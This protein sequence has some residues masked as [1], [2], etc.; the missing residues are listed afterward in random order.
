[1]ELLTSDELADYRSVFRDAIVGGGDPAAAEERLRRLGLLPEQARQIRLDYEKDAGIIRAVPDPFAV[2][3]DPNR[4]TWFAGPQLADKFWPRVRTSLD[5]MLPS[6]AVESIDESSNYVLSIMDP[7]GLSSIDTRG[8]VV[9]YVQSGKTTNF[10]SLISK[11]AD[12]GYRVFIVLSGITENLRSQTQQRVDELLVGSHAGDWTKLTTL[13]SDFTEGTTNAAAMLGQPG[14]RFIAVVKKNPA[15]LRRLHKWL[16][17]AGLVALQNAPILLIDDE[18]DQASINV[19][20]LNKRASTINDLLKHILNKP[21]AAY[22][23]YTATP[24]ANLLIDTQDDEDLYPRDFVV[25]LPEPDEYFGP[26][27]LFGLD[28]GDAEIAQD[29]LDVIRSIPIDEAARSRP[30][31]GRDAVDKWA[32]AVEPALRDA[33]R[34]FIMST[35]ARM[36]RGEGNAHATMLVHTSMLARAHELLADEIRIEIESCSAG[37]NAGSDEFVA[38]WREQYLSEVSAVEAANFGRT[39]VAFGD[40][41][42]RVPEVLQTIHVICDN[43]RSTERLSYSA[44][45]AQVTIVVGGNTLSRGLTLEGLSS[46]YFVRAASAYDALLQMGRWFGYRIG[47]EDLCRI[48]MTDELRD[49][50]RDLSTV[51]WEVRQDIRRY[52]DEG[53]TPRE[54]AVRIREH[55]NMAVTSRAKMRHAVQ[56][57]LS[58]SGQ[59]TQTILF[60][61]TNGDWLNDNRLAVEGLV[62]A[63]QAD[64]KNVCEFPLQGRR[65]FANVDVARIHEFLGKYR[66]HESSHRAD[67]ELIRKYIELENEA[68][69]LLKWNVVFFENPPDDGVP[70]IDIGLAN[71][72]PLTPLRRARMKTA[73][74]S[75]AN[76]KAIASKGDRGADLD[77]RDEALGARFSAL[78]AGVQPGSDDAYRFV[79]ERELP[80]VGM[81]GI[82]PIA[83]DSLAQ[84]GAKSRKDL[85]AAGDIFGLT[86]FFPRAK[87]QHSTVPYVMANLQAGAEDAEN[88]ETEAEEIT[89]ADEADEQRAEEADEANAAAEVSS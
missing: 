8:L 68:D 85:D 20:G 63:I 15:R 9:G 50:F 79:K 42:E 72:R 52:R 1:M 58:Y 49:W 51:E 57:Q 44:D 27:Q 67:G 36:V 86:F 46:S 28:E 60:E 61:R 21:K 22:V 62:A 6:S 53:A 77:L 5:A 4:F 39:T 11:G 3:E 10:I 13:E 47:Y 33:I 29:G 41:W 55:P 30:G 38:G 40:L 32:P 73:D 37:V 14:M 56:A 82:Y 12:V 76:L 81:L 74:D 17:A 2:L 89:A 66:F 18:A 24:F 59:R 25:S 83:A 65:G 43:Y 26:R 34:W 70:G 23:G 31:R 35:A 88:L 48:W 45:A 80:R 19:A 54:L 78:P 71:G 87:G 16:N 84:E 64:G 69:S 7:P 75:I